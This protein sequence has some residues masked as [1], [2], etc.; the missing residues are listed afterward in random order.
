MPSYIE[1]TG[2]LLHRTA[3]RS[4]RFV[5]PAVLLS[6]ILLSGRME[7]L[8]QHSAFVDAVDRSGFIF[9]G[10][11][12]AVGRSTPTIA[13]T[14]N[15][16]VVTVDRVI[17][18]FPP[19]GNP[20]GKDVTVRVRDPQ[21]LRKGQR[22]IFFTYLQTAGATL[23]LVEVMLQPQTQS[24]KA[25]I[26]VKE[27]RQI[28]ADEALTR[29]LTSAQAVVVGVFGEPQPTDEARERKG[30]H[31]PMWWRGDIKVESFE[32]GQRTD[33]PVV[34]NFASSDDV[35]WE[36]SPKPKAGERAIFLLQ[37]HIGKPIEKD[38]QVP[39]LFLIDPLDVRPVTE[40]E[41]VRRLIKTSAH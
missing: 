35:V 12:K 26:Q 10:T 13:R 21:K 39:G 9:V 16:V 38:Y 6:C 28:L 15:S 25:E 19:I 30:E 36:G 14:Q 2:F 29:R 5:L 1:P 22:A 40:L 33:S 11:V 23:G 37:P 34:V 17:E 18:A 20:T 41:R 32:K 31:D 8:A 4:R 27:A 3:L 7:L 24:D